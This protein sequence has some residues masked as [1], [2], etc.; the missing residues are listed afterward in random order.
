MQEGDG[1]MPSPSVFLLVGVTIH[2]DAPARLSVL[3]FWIFLT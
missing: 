2:Y 1:A 3:R